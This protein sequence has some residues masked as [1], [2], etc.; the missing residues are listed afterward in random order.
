MIGFLIFTIV[1]QLMV[2]CMLF[3]WKYYE[4]IDDYGYHGRKYKEQFL[5]FREKNKWWHFIIPFYWVYTIIQSIRE[6]VKKLEE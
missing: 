6:G 1:I 4:A 3:L 5:S 2:F